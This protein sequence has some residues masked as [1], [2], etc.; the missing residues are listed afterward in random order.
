MLWSQE[1]QVFITMISH[2][3]WHRSLHN[4]KHLWPHLNRRLQD[5]LHSGYRCKGRSFGSSQHF[6]KQV[7]PHFGIGTSIRTLHCALV[8]Q[9]L[10]HLRGQLC[11]HD[12]FLGHLSLHSSGHFSPHIEGQSCLHGNFLEHGLWQIAVSSSWH[13]TF[14]VCWQAAKSFVIL[15]GH[16]HSS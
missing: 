12:I 8:K 7:C 1:N 6:T 4:L 16:R 9:T 3:V 10:P 11:P 2:L 13:F 15:T 14:P 5:W